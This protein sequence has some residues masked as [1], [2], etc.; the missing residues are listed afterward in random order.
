MMSQN[1]QIFLIEALNW[2]IQAVLLCL[3][4]VRPWLVKRWHLSDLFGY[5][6]ILSVFWCIWRM[7]IFDPATDNDVP[8][9][10]YLAVG[11]V[12]GFI[13]VFLHLLRC[14]FTRRPVTAPPANSLAEKSARTVCDP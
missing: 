4:F 1:W 3:A 5:P 11:F 10:G 14:A 13:A 8:G 2:F 7:V 6:M 12:L 9:M